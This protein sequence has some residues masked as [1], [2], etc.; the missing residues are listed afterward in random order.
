MERLTLCVRWLLNPDQ[1]PQRNCRLMIEDNVLVDVRPARVEDGDVLPLMIVPPLVNAHT[2]LE[3]SNLSQPLQP[4]TPFP[5]WIR[6]V[7]RWRNEVG[8]AAN[9][10][11]TAIKAGL[12][13]SAASG[14]QLV[15]EIATSNPDPSSAGQTK[16]LIFREVIGLRASRCAQ[17]LLMLDRFLKLRPEIEAAGGRVGISPHAPYSVH[18]DFLYLLASTARQEKLPLAMHLGETREEQELLEHGTGPFA[19][20]LKSLD[21]FDAEIFRG[22]RAW[23]EYLEQLTLAPHAL[24]IHGNWFGSAEWDYLR[25]HPTI[26]VVYCPRTHHWF[27]H[28][29]YPLQEMLDAGVRVVLGTDSRA[30]NP[31]LGIWN[32]LKHVLQHHPGVDPLR[33]LAMITTSSAAALGWPEVSQPIQPGRPFN[34]T[35]IECPTQ[36]SSLREEMCCSRMAA[37][38]WQWLS[39]NHH[40]KA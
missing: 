27:G 13:E 3:F 6:S 17:Q 14:V 1:Q 25:Q 9:S 19:E 10:V 28:P 12:A 4:P 20:F 39:V 40:K 11:Q 7:I 23:T 21:L 33:M 37:V 32:E 22:G 30:S 29:P 36:E 18:P 5:D 35:M 15:G 2:H 16:S 26:T 8:A 31:D 38:Q 24:A 34:A